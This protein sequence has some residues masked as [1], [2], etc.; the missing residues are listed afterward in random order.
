[1]RLCGLME[2]DRAK[3]LIA[4]DGR[5]VEA[6]MNQGL[7]SET[8]GHEPGGREFESL[9]ARVYSVHLGNTLASNG[10]AAHRSPKRF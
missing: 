5:F 2:Y 7:G 6:A 1:V 9:R 8:P 4:K 10:F 3:L